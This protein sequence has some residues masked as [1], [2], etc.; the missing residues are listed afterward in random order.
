MEQLKMYF[1]PGTPL[2]APPL[3]EGITLSRFDGSE[4]DL[5]AWAECLR[6]GQLIEG[7][8]DE[9][10][11]ADTIAGIDDIVPTEDIWFLDKNGEHV[12]TV[13]GF[14]YRD[15]N[16]G[17]IHMVGVRKDCRGQGLSKY[18]L[19]A[20]TGHVL[21]KGPR[22]IKLTTDEFRRA[23]IRSYL[24]MG[25]RPVLY[26]YGMEKRWLAV[27]ESFGVD[28]LDMLYEDASFFRT[29][30]LGETP[31]RVKVG[32]L[33]AGRGLS[34]MSYCEHSDNAELV[35]VC[36]SDPACLAEVKAR[37]PGVALYSDY[38][39]F[40]SHGFDL[41]V[42]ANYA[43]EHA[44]FAVKALERGVNVLSELLPVQNMAEAVALVEAVEKSGKL[45]IYGENCCFMP[46]P[47]KMY[48]L[49]KKGRLGEFRYGEGEYL[50][51][52]EPDWQWHS[53]ARRD[54]WRNRMTA[55]YY[56]THS[57]GPLVRMAGSRPVSVTGFEAPYTEKM[58][59]MGAS[60][61]PFG[62]EVVTLESGAIIKSLHGVGPAKYSLWFRAEGDK[63]V[64]ESARD[65]AENGGVGTLLMNADET[66]GSDDGLFHDTNVTDGLTELA[67]GAGHGGG[68]YYLLYNAMERVKGNKQAEVIGVYEALDMFLPGLFAYFSVLDGGRPQAIPDLRDP[69][70]RERWR[71]DTRC[72]DPKAAGDQLLPSYSKGNPDIPDSVYEELMKKR[73]K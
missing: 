28:S 43:N 53:H 60:G 27:M 52:C 23:A 54:H 37:Y 57:L 29:L 9:Q 21:K 71:H 22:Y 73:V 35:A 24:S 42:L 62:M 26:D 7:R 48:K 32:V 33:G 1:L 19:A 20:A 56:C 59:R 51:N 14:L 31:E 12:A 66:E 65:L 50:H 64:V 13:T 15:E 44:P 47:Y 6:D 3:P 4:K 68:D 2:S 16:V 40:L 34:I 39:A 67:E 25:F 69:A 17:D 63:G 41:A 5:H 38:D 36:D 46:A 58:R 70:E 11:Y 18:V 61:A 49:F 55:F 72:T 30:S 8:S 10:A 45:Y